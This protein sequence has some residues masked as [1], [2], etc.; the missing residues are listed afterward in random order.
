MMSDQDWTNE[1]L[2]RGRAFDSQLKDVK[3]RKN[4]VS[5]YPYQSMTNLQHLSHLLPED[6]IQGL[7]G[8]QAM[9]VLDIGAA[10]GDLGFFFESRGATV[11]FLDNPPTNFNDCKGLLALRD[12]LGSKARLITMDIDRGVELEKQYDFAIALGLLYHLRNPMLFLFALAQHAE[13]M[14]LSTRVANHFPNGQAIGD[15]SVAYLW[16]CREANNDPTNYWCFSTAGLRT[17]LKRCGWQIVSE[18]LFGS[19]TSDPVAV[20]RDQRM[21]VYC[22]RIPN[23]RDLGKHHDF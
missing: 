16:S 20:D 21:F 19:E 18:A 6:M 5:W 4:D 15:V 12:A 7:L 2:A 8:G 14:V 17:A 10:D 11:D 23:W 9:S 1:M 13:T 3:L 22:K